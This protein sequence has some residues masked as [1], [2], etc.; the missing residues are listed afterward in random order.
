MGKPILFVAKKTIQ[1]RTIIIIAES[2]VGTGVVNSGLER[3]AFNR[4]IA[5]WSTS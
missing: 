4:I 1:R 3:E 2:N 5:P